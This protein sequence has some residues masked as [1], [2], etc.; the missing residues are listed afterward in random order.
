VRKDTVTKED[1][2]RYVTNSIMSVCDSNE[3]HRPQARR[4]ARAG[5]TDL[6]IVMA[7]HHALFRRGMRHL[8]TERY[9][10]LLIGEAA[11]G[12][13]MQRLMH[14]PWDLII[15]EATLPGMAGEAAVQTLCRAQ[16]STPVLVL[17]MHPASVYAVRM[18]RAGAKGYFDKAAPGEEFIKAIDALRAGRY[19]VSEDASNCLLDFLR[20]RPDG[21]AH[22]L[23]S[24]R[25]FQV[26]TMLA[27]GQ[28]LKQIA[29]EL[30]I[31]T[32]SV[33][34]YRSRVLD[35]LHLSGNAELARYALEDGIVR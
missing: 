4:L 29:N 31:S 16:P 13:E 5:Q 28:T 18:L 12:D 34:T 2:M 7:D 15:M 20:R 19:Y 32:N 14:R 33:S 3:H 1:A 11:T 6:K 22:D 21:L 24:T 35:K 30:N 9:G 26:L 17:S 10:F 27:A 8:L 25:E 23:L